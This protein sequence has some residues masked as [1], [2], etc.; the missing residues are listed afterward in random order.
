[1][2]KWVKLHQSKSLFEDLGAEYL[3][4]CIANTDNIVHISKYFSEHW[5]KSKPEESRWLF[6]VRFTD[7]SVAVGIH[8]ITEVSLN[9]DMYP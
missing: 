5:D 6:K 8:R 4:D 9:D 3:E 7:G 2:S 1:M